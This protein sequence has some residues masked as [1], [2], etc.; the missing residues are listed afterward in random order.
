MSIDEI[1][2]ALGA[3]RQDAENARESRRITHEKIDDLT[4]EVREIAPRVA[5]LEQL[6]PEIRDFMAWRDRVKGGAA[7]F[8]VIG[9]AIGAVGGEV[10]RLLLHR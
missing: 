8:W 4:R 3:L 5:H 1:S 6:A 7:V 9:I 2:A 10:A